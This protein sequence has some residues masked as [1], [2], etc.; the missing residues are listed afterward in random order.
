MKNYRN[1]L[2]KLPSDYTFGIEL[3]FTG[4]LTSDETELIINH[5]IEKGYIRKGWAVHFDKSVIDEEGK[6]AEIVSPV[7]TDTKQTEQELDIILRVINLI[8][9]KMTDKVG[10]HIHYGTQC[11]GNNIKRINGKRSQNEIKSTLV[12]SCINA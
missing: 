5:L 10:C 3:E 6:G 2:N 4:G 8:G 1:Y 12:Y 11:L 7:L 9:G